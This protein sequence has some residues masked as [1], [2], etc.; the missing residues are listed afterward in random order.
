MVEERY[1]PAV[2]VRLATNGTIAM[3]ERPK[4]TGAIILFKIISYHSRS[5]GLFTASKS[6]SITWV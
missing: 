2:V 3:T 1:L 4:G 6:V 5:S